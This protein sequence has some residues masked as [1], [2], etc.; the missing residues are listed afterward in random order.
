MTGEGKEAGLY[1]KR[2][3]MQHSCKKVLAVLYW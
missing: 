1:R 2:L 3:R